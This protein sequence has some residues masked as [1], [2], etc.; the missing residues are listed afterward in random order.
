MPGTYTW[1]VKLID[2]SNVR[3]SADGLTV[4]AGALVFE[5][6]SPRGGTD[7]V[8]VYAPGTYISVTK[9]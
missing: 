6:G 8:V 2:G 1:N 9:I 7:V 4:N 5:D 3:V